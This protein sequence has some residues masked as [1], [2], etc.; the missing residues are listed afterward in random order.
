[1]DPPE[2]FPPLD[3]DRQTV[4]AVMP[5]WMG[6]QFRSVSET[7]YK[8]EKYPRGAVTVMAV[9]PGSAAANAGIEVGD[10]IL[11]PPD[12]PFTEPQQVR[13]WTMRREIGEPAPL[14][15]AR[16]GQTMQITL[17]PEPYPMKMPELPGPPKV[18]SAAPPLKLEPFRGDRAFAAGHPRL[19][20]FWATWCVPCKAALPE[21]LAFA[22][23]RG[24]EV[25]AVTD[26]DPDTLTAFFDQFKQPFPSKPV[27]LIVPFVA[28]G[29]ADV[30]GRIL[31]QRLAQQYGQQV[32]VENRP[33][34]GGHVGAE[35]AAHAA[36]DGY[37]IVFGTIGIHAA[38][39][40]Y[41]KLSYDPARDLQAVALYADV[42]CVLIV[43]PSVPA[44]TVRN[45]SRWRSRIPAG[46]ISVL[47]AAVR[48]RTW[49][50]SGSG[51]SP[52]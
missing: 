32:Y 2:R 3:E 39:T 12:A 25:V 14:T 24:I 17:H 30:L 4:T 29:S 11:G 16:G 50:V 13:E 31:A 34:S 20:F 5:A 19:L 8:K 51:S 10:V 48:R 37:T 43:H 23:S 42:P 49:W 15:V 22:K 40:I 21:V 7:I 45:S 47:R 52:A 6:I 33:G 18:G 26:E 46:S 41:S 36:P 44:R 27:R 35:A 28:G 1:M 38:Y 9:Y